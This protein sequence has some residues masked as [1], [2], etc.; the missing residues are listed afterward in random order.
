MEAEQ[1]DSDVRGDLR[2]ADRSELVQQEHSLGLAVSPFPDT[3]A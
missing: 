2:I 3:D 1:Q